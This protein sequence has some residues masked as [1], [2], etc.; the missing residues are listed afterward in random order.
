MNEIS[1][2]SDYASGYTNESIFDSRNGQD[3]FLHNSVLLWGLPSY[4]WNVYNTLGVNGY[5]AAA[6]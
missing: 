5:K 3:I 1:I 2:F 6:A 4:M